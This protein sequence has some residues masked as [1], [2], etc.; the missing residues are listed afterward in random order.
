MLE[1]S[2]EGLDSIRCDDCEYGDDESPVGEIVIDI[3][4]L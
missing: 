2:E 3:D 1:S 4:G